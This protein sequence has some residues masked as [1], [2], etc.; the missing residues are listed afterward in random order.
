MNP[1][2]GS[3]FRAFAGKSGTV[4]LV[5]AATKFFPRVRG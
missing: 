2:N 1:S 5:A 4:P 3:S